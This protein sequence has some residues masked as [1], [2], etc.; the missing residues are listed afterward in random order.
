MKPA[1]PRILTAPVRLPVRARGKA[2]RT[3][4]LWPFGP[5]RRLNPAWSLELAAGSQPQTIR[6]RIPFGDLRKHLDPIMLHLEQLDGPGWNEHLQLEGGVNIPYYWSNLRNLVIP[7]ATQI[8]DRETGPQFGEGMGWCIFDFAEAWGLFHEEDPTVRWTPWDLWGELFGS[9]GDYGIIAGIT[10]HSGSDEDVQYHPPLQM[11]MYALLLALRDE[12]VLHPK[13]TVSTVAPVVPPLVTIFEPGPHEVPRD[14]DLG[15][16]MGK[17]RARRYRQRRKRDA[18]AVREE[19]VEGQLSYQGADW[20]TLLF[21][22]E[23]SPAAYQATKVSD[24]SEDDAYRI[25]SILF[26][27]WATC[28]GVDC[29][30]IHGTAEEVMSILAAGP[31][32]EPTEYAVA[33]GIPGYTGPAIQGDYPNAPLPPP[34]ESYNL[35]GGPRLP[36]PEMHPEATHGQREYGLP[37]NPEE[38]LQKALGSSEEGPRKRK[39]GAG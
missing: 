18:A 6:Y 11:S 32:S 27:H 20:P 8:S 26:E 3:R 31:W 28:V 22:A 10:V 24:L 25:K 39:E 2:P 5:A 33:P 21:A 38:W 35:Y 36:A 29:F 13:A 14:A 4:P 23:V 19:L 12:G 37:W 17:G 1:R 16:H 15:G 30:V 7:L 34:P 9:S